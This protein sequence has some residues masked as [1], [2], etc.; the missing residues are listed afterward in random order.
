MAA[1]I[2]TEFLASILNRTYT[3]TA[4][5]RQTDRQTTPPHTHTQ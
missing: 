5:Q 2:H 3:D 4:R 1:R